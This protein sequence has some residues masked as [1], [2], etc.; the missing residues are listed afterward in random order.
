[1]TSKGV[2]CSYTL[3]NI[4]TAVSVNN[5]NTTSAVQRDNISDYLEVLEIS[6][7]K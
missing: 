3:L 6:I 2:I 5:I 4:L 7:N 1:M